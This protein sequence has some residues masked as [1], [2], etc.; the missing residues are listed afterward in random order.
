MIILAWERRCAIV[1]ISIV[2]DSSPA[3]SA[4]WLQRSTERLVFVAHPTNQPRSSFSPERVT[5]FKKSERTLQMSTSPNKLWAFGPIIAVPLLAAAYYIKVPAFREAV[6][7]RIPWA[8]EHLSQFVPAPKVV[9]IHDPKPVPA[10]SAGTLPAK[11]RVT[12]ANE[13]VVPTAPAAPAAA[14]TGSAGPTLQ[15]FAANSSLWPKSVRL[16]AATEF[17]AVVNGRPIGKIQAPAG[18]ETRLV[19]IRGEQLGLEFQ[20][21][22][23]WVPI[24]QT[25][26]MQ[27]VKIATR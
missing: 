24:S 16:R 4:V 19:T 14:E 1:R 7:I 23:A 21:G 2:W 10:P 22:G 20:G 11:S 27:R 5:N 6:D 12:N 25:D 17:P 26:L 13:P 18:T 15:E 9:I 3:S 8:K